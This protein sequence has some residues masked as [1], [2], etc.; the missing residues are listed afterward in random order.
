M[1]IMGF[2]VK[3]VEKRGKKLCIFNLVRFNSITSIRNLR[4]RM[5]IYLFKSFQAR[6]KYMTLFVYEEMELNVVMLGFCWKYTHFDLVVALL[7]M[8][9]A[10]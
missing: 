6:K 2:S 5:L 4:R 10:E 8:E 7:E 3:S 9:L 1:P